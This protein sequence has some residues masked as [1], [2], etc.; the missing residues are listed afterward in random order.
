MHL[1]KSI[2]FDLNV[3]FC[4]GSKIKTTQLL[5]CLKHLPTTHS[6]DSH[7]RDCILESGKQLRK[8]QYVRHEYFRI[9]A[10]FESK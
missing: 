5:Q 10:R 4:V 3:D 8:V 7:G 2:V 9:L 6:R 1:L